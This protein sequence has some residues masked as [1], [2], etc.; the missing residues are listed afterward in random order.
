MSIAE[1]TSNITE[2]V[3]STLLAD[4][5]ECERQ[6][7]ELGAA[8]AFRLIYENPSYE[9]LCML[10][11]FSQNWFTDTEEPVDVNFIDVDVLPS[12]LGAYIITGFYT[13]IVDIK[14]SLTEVTA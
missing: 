7:L 6:A 8:Q 10:A 2:A 5:K 11:D 14:K 1:T 9:F 3:L 4:K 13:A 12:A